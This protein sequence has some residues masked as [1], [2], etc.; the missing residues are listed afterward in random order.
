MI[1]KYDGYSFMGTRAE[2]IKHIT[3]KYATA[4]FTWDHGFCCLGE[5]RAKV[6]TDDTDL[7]RKCLIEQICEKVPEEMTFEYSGLIYQGA[8]SSILTRLRKRLEH[9]NLIWDGDWWRLGEEE[10]REIGHPEHIKELLIERALVKVP[11]K[12]V[13]NDQTF[14]D[15]SQLKIHLENLS[16][17]YN[18]NTRFFLAGFSFDSRNQPKN[19]DDIK[20]TIIK[21]ILAGIK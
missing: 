19:V 15:M 16:M 18:G 20:A 13:F 8:R 5:E 21:D 7:I 17:V 4:K 6:R 2:V 12:I 10:T 3:Q 14:S 1:F 11:R 9:L